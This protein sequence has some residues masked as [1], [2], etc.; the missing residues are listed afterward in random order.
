MTEPANADAV[1]VPAEVGDVAALAADVA[2]E[3]AGLDGAVL[4]AVLELEL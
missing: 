3:A 1:L 4:A 2:A